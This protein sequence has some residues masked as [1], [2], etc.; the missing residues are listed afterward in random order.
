MTGVLLRRGIFGQR[1]HHVKT[2]TQ[3]EVHV[4][5]EAEIRTCISKPGSN[6]HAGS[7][8]S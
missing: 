6:K 3:G 7:I 2:E 1:G 5:M 8:R 4:K